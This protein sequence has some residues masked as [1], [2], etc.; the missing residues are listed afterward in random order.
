[1]SSNAR[2][3]IANE[4]QPKKGFSVKEDDEIFEL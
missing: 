4:S 1:M 2:K 3:K